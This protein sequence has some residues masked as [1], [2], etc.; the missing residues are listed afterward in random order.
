MG[1]INEK[2][3]FVLHYGKRNYKLLMYAMMYEGELL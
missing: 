3:N 1:N 2:W